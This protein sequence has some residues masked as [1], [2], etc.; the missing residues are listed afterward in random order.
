[1]MNRRMLFVVAISLFVSLALVADQAVILDT[2]GKSVALVDLSSGALVKRLAL[3]AEPY[4]LVRSPD[5]SRLIVLFRGSGEV[6]DGTWKPMGN[7]SAQVVDARSLEN[8]RVIDIDVGKGARELITLGDQRT[9][10]AVS[11]AQLTLLDTQ[12]NKMAKQIPLKGGVT[13]V[14]ATPTGLA[15]S[16]PRRVR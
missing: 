7:A 12:T 10:L 9:V 5:G 13:A 4:E 14:S 15:S 1:M 2:E 11:D 16:L 3:T 8:E 6:R